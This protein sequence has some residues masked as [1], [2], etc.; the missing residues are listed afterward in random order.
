MSTK[1]D[2]NKDYAGGDYEEGHEIDLQTAEQSFISKAPS[3]ITEDTTPPSPAS[4]PSK[5]KN[6]KAAGGGGGCCT[7]RCILFVV[8]AMI[9]LVGVAVALSIVFLGSPNPLDFLT[10][11]PSRNE[12]WT[13]QT[14]EGSNGLS[15]TIENALDESWDG[16]FEEYIERWDAGSDNGDHDP[17]ALTVELVDPDSDCSP[18]PGRLKVCN[19]DYG[20]TGWAG[21]NISLLLGTTMINS[22][23]KLNDYILNSASDARRKYTM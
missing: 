23:S 1:Q 13:W 21:I 20:D 12:T 9:A 6:R 8:V 18:T 2:N 17:L 14:A 22:V 3:D 5:K 7:S 4:S 15:L 10:Q 19:G 11:E 16:I